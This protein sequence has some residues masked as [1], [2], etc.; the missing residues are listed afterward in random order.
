LVSCYCLFSRCRLF[1]V[2]RPLNGLFVLRFRAIQGVLPLTDGRHCLFKILGNCETKRRIISKQEQGQAQGHGGRAIRYVYCWI[3]RVFVA[4]FGRSGADFLR[5][6]YTQAGRLF[7]KILRN[8]DAKRGLSARAT[9]RTRARAWRRSA[10][11][12]FLSKIAGFHCGFR[13]IWADFLRVVYTQA[14]RFF[15]KI[16][17]NSGAKRRIISQATARTSARAWRR[18]ATVLFLL[19]TENFYCGFREIWADFLRVVY[20]QRRAVQIWRADLLAFSGVIYA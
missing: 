7:F 14:R 10:T 6:V 20:P 4:D 18:T 5:V 11:V 3:L 19:K 9:A 2:C 12:L 13:S 17:R 8:C 15:S 1:V 16:L